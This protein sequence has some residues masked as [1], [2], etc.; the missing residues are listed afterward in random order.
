MRMDIL[1]LLYII[2]TA[3]A[4]G[5]VMAEDVYA[6]QPHPPFP[7]SVKDGYAVIGEGERV[8]RDRST[9][10]ITNVILL[11]DFMTYG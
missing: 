5:A 8:V 10:K 1:L 4:L 9:Q 7:A 6:P 2:L 11:C 3:E